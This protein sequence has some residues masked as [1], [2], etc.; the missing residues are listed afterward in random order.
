MDNQITI[1]PFVLNCLLCLQQDR[2]VMSYNLKS[3]S[4]ELFS[5]MYHQPQFREFFRD[6]AGEHMKLVPSDPETIFSNIIAQKDKFTKNVLQLCEI[7][8][9]QNIF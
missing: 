5:D 1:S 2:Y 6:A 4:H 7:I 3:N 9:T 8:S